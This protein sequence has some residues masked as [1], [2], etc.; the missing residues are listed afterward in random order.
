MFVQPEMPVLPTGPAE[1]R[2]SLSLP[3]P[4]W[5][6]SETISRIPTCSRWG[7]QYCQMCPST[8][9]LQKVFIK[10]M[11]FKDARQQELS[12]QLQRVKLFQA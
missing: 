12:K 11:K 6:I 2:G 7:Q 4:S 9:G 3:S 8:G 10:V 1:T 5:A